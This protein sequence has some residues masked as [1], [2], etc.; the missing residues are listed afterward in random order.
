MCFSFSFQNRTKS[1]VW[2]FLFMNY[3]NLTNSNHS[4]GRSTATIKLA[5]LQ[6]NDYPKIRYVSDFFGAQSEIFSLLCPP[7]RLICQPFAPF[8]IC[9]CMYYFN[10]Q[11]IVSFEYIVFFHSLESYQTYSSLP[12]HIIPM[13]PSHLGVWERNFRLLRPTYFLQFCIK[14]KPIKNII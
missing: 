7:V 1:S 12:R 6:A 2:H 10:R 14:G 5:P 4:A 3:M 11:F 13:C 9:L 8:G